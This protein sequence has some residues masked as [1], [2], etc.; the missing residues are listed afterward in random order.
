[1]SLISKRIHVPNFISSVSALFFSVLLLCATCTIALAQGGVGSSRGLPSS[2][3]G[4]NIIRG[5]VF[6]P[7][8]TRDG[9]RIKVRLTSTDFV[10]QTVSTDEDGA[11][12]FNGLPNGHYT[13]I[14]D[15]GKDFDT[16]TESVSIDR[17]AS[18]GARNLSV[19][20]TLRPKG[21]AAAFNKI[22][23]GARELYVKGTEAAAKGDSKKA[24]EQFNGALALYPEFAQAL[25]DLGVQY[26]RLNQPDKAVESFK[27][28]LKLTP[29]DPGLLLSYGI[30]LLNQKKYP[31]AETELHAALKKNDNLPTAHMYLGITLMSQQKFDEAEKALQRAV[32]FKSNEVGTAHRY[33]GGI[34]W[35][36]HDYQRAAD[37]LET[38]LK[39]VPNAADAE[40]TRAAIKDLRGKK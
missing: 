40:R 33:L 26:L 20:I 3:G 11:F 18:P 24:V 39:M 12:V 36:N 23:K 15:G 1:M 2:T 7:S 17:E 5:R 32:S 8:E 30:A 27:A 10:D 25:N 34:Y 19:S 4:N 21:T 16:A 38:Y 9:K 28:A 13:V 31:E 29:D 14:V 6:F 35:R 37:E 22:P